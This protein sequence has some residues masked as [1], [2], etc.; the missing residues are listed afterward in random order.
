MFGIL[1]EIF[2]GLF[3][4]S[5]VKHIVGLSQIDRMSKDDILDQLSRPVHTVNLKI[6]TF[7]PTYGAGM[8]A[9]PFVN[10]RFKR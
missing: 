7:T 4:S 3:E 1:T 2:S 6:N 8:Q 10:P 5:S 9:S